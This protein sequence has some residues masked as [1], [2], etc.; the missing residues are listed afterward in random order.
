MDYFLS[1]E[2]LMVKEI[3]RKIAEEKIR[4]VRQEYDKE[5]KFPDDILQ[6]IARADLFRVFIPEEYEGMGLGLSGLC[7]ATEELSRVCGGIA[8]SYAVAGLGGLPI[9]LFGTEEQK[10]KYLPPIASGE[11]YAAFAL[12]EAEA[13]SDAGGIK[14]TAVKD[15]D[16]YILNGTKQFITNGGEADIYVVIASTNPKRGERGLSA[17]IVEKG[18][19]GFTFGKEE[20]KMGIRASATRELVFDECRIPAENILGKEGQG[21]KVA[22]ET[23]DRSRLGVAAQALGIAQGA[24]EEALEYSKQRHQFGQPISSFQLIQGKLADMAT[25]VEAARALL[26]SA[27]KY[28]DANPKKRPTRIGAMAKLFCSDVAMYVTTEAVQIFGGYGYMRDYPVEK[29]M[30][31]AKITQIYEGTNEIQKLTIAL[32]LIRRGFKG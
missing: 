28:V 30:R 31:D 18:T 13:G 19:E 11:K 1:E 6:E 16:Y 12:T 26:Y 29:M 25:Q 17:F 4:P 22:I 9:I 5:G 7:I 23:L 10:Q 8:I 3:A 24:L 2:L 27:M 32:D 14:T 20:D 15:G 21:L